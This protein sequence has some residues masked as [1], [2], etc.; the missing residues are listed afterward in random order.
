MEE[1]LRAH[2]MGLFEGAP[3]T[4]QMIEVREE[5]LTNVRE[6]YQ[7]LIAAGASPE[8]A[9]EIS[10]GSIGNLEE[11]M[12]TLEEQDAAEGITFAA[13]PEDVEAKKKKYAL[14]GIAVALF[15]LSP[16]WLIA[17][18][19]FDA[20]LAG[21]IGMFAFIA[22]GSGLKVYASGVYQPAQNVPVDSSMME[23]YRQWHSSRQME[24]RQLKL[25]EGILW[26]LIVA[27]YFI[28][29]FATH[30]WYITWVIFLIGAAI[31]QLMKL[32]VSK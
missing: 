5:I 9:Y 31:E 2:V 29:S 26:P 10:K 28:I 3:M 25:Y 22:I 24:Q 13:A 17:L 23:E 21:L 8:E 30:A 18:S 1:K 12:K 4:K 19:S 7:D 11:I 15:I 32:A 14:D 27:A 6:R 16:V 20:W